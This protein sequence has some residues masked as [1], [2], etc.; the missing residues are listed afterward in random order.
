MHLSSNTQRFSCSRSSC[1]WTG[2]PKSLVSF[3][4]GFTQIGSGWRVLVTALVLA[5][6]L[7][8]VPCCLDFLLD[9]SW[10]A[11]LVLG[12]L[13]FSLRQSLLLSLSLLLL[14]LPLIV[15]GPTLWM[16]TGASPSGQD[17][18]LCLAVQF[19]G[20]EITVRGPSHQALDF[21]QGLTTGAEN[22]QRNR[23]YEG[24]TPPA[25]ALPGHPVCP[26]HILA[27]STK[28][29]AASCLSPI[30]RVQRA[31]DL[32]CRAKL[33]LDG[34][35]LP[36]DPV[37]AVDLPS[38]F[39]VVLRGANIREPKIFRSQRDFNRAIEGTELP[40]VGHDFPSQ[41]EVKAYFA[42]AGLREP[43]T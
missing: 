37:V 41:T 17:D 27:L 19:Q 32:G 18:T 4:P 10:G 29:S 7:S 25:T 21:V 39:F 5:S 24:A 15:S 36:E 26:R 16:S 11:W 8:L 43:S 34:R 35:A 9:L 3:P 13:D 30:E 20:L 12:L 23:P 40:G 2:S 14:W 38:S 28:L 31:W 1:G 22:N 33:Q 6:R 42:G